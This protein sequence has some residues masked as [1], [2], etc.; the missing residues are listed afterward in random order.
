MIKRFTLHDGRGMPDLPHDADVE[1]TDRKGG[2]RVGWPVEFDW[3]HRNVSSDIIGWRYLTPKPAA[4]P[5]AP[6]L[7]TDS[8]ERKNI[9]LATGCFDYFPDALC[10]VASLS[11]AGNDKHNPGQPLH[12]AREKSNDHA[13]TILRHMVE[14]GTI[15]TDGHRHSAKVAWRA[16]A[17]LQVEIEEARNAAK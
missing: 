7:T 15:D 16:L 3:K 1:V 13:D 2:C 8:A 4:S 11:K 12:W 6:R 17:Q 10:A 9:P 14:R 5:P